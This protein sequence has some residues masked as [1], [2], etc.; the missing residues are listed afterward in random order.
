MQ[1]RSLN[2]SDMRFISFAVAT[3]LCSACQSDGTIGAPVPNGGEAA[4]EQDVPGQPGSTAQQLPD[5]EQDSPQPGAEEQTQVNTPSGSGSAVASSE[6]P[7]ANA[8]SPSTVAGDPQPT[9]ASTASTG[10]ASEADTDVAAAAQGAAPVDEGGPAEAPTDA[11]P[12]PDVVVRQPA[13]DS[14][15]PG[16]SAPL[17][18]LTR[19]SRCTTIDI[20]EDDQV[21]A[22]VNTD[23]DSVSFF[24]ASTATRTGV[25]AVDGKPSSIV[26]H[27][28]GKTAFAVSR[29]GRSVQ[30]I[31]GIDTDAPAV[32]ARLDV[33]AEP[34]CAALS[35]DGSTLY[36]TEWAEGNIA[37]IATEDMRLLQLL[38]AP[39]NPYG[40]TVTSELV[41]ATE[42]YGTRSARVDDLGSDQMFESGVVRV[43]ETPD[44]NLGVADFAE[45]SPIV[46]GARD[47][48]F[49]D[50]RSPEET[51]TI[52]PN[53]LHSVMLNDGKVYVTATG[54]APLGGPR[55]DA[56]VFSMIYVADLET[57]TEDTGALG[58]QNL[59]ALVRDNVEENPIFAADLLT[60]DFVPETNVAY[61]VSR[62]GDMVQR[63]RFDGDEVEFGSSSTG[64]SQI[65]VG[66]TADRCQAP[67]GI[68][69]LHA[70]GGAWVNCFANF[71]VSRLDFATQSAVEFAESTEATTS[72]AVNR[73]RRF[74]HTGLAQWSKNAWSSC[75]SCHPNGLSD[76]VTYQFPAGPRQSTEL[77]SS[78]LEED[79]QLV[80][81][82]FN[83]TA[84]FDEIHDF[85]TNTT[86]VQGGARPLFP[87]DGEDCENGTVGFTSAAEFEGGLASPMSLVE[88]GSCNPDD[89]DE[90]QAYI[91]TIP[92]AR[93]LARVEPAAI[94]RGYDVFIEGRCNNCHGGARSTLSRLF[95]EPSPET[96]ALLALEPF[97]PPEQWLP[98]WSENR[99]TQIQ[100]QDPGGP[101]EQAPPQVSCVLRQVGTFGLGTDD[102]VTEAIERR[103]ND[104]RSQGEGGYNIP[105]LY[106][107]G[108]GAPYLHHGAAETLD[109]LFSE[110]A[111]EAHWQAGNANFLTG[112]DADDKRRDLI[113]YLLSLDFE[114]RPTPDPDAGMDG[115][116]SYF[117]AA[118]ASEVTSY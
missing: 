59:A 51:T 90:L 55:F 18:R 8:N 63:L 49:A 114:T 66:N 83:W 85:S 61:A 71:K 28:N 77:G 95:Y 43:F 3:V 12:D 117:D 57:R 81:R 11:A 54:V 116:P 19:P 80:Q 64:V 109:E 88:D 118:T 65:V 93:G 38:D 6:S 30:R 39:D 76:N 5:G 25:V 87:E 91:E 98:A 46:F 48:T 89:F 102:A 58:T 94:E 82:I 4:G 108:L 52:G 73:G 21:V 24:D 112:S 103:A 70:G 41:L 67:S 31:D 69:T 68:V 26:V 40:L 79:G 78:F 16:G 1:Q 32:G 33:G 7:P 10:I 101:T 110:P 74:F 62:G 29:H 13:A 15:A 96:N 50:P 105:S 92:P 53:Q 106:G 104:A 34:V 111:F 23:A 27:P 99:T 60:I 113:A 72:A 14:P 45:T 86:L 115:C 37:I 17:P 44:T 107:L 47:S 36:V 20:S 35:P 42:F 56:N 2:L 22:V 9:P 97:T 75:S 84:V 100:V